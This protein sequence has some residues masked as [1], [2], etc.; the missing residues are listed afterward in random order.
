MTVG[1]LGLLNSIK[2]IAKDSVKKRYRSVIVFRPA[3]CLPLVALLLAG[4]QV[5]FISAYDFATD[6]G[7]TGLQRSVENHLAQLDELA[8]EPPGL[9]S[10][11]E[12]C[13]PEKFDDTYR[14]L[15]SGLQVL[16]IRN[17]ARAKNDLTVQQL[18]LLGESFDTLRKQQIERYTPTDP[19]RRI[20]KP[21]DRCMSTAQ[22][23][24]NRDILQQHIR[25]ILKLELA[26]RE[27][28][29]EE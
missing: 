4:C 15:K 23:A 28:R 3:H 19:E 6:Q 1:L 18:K 16:V 22:I 13:K 7:V 11:V 10:L 9:E 17:E 24:L 2:D 21:G 14:E 8:V 29:S 20:E 26:K 25:A 27:F 5:H 12:D